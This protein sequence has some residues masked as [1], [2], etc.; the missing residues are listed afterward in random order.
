MK[1]GLRKRSKAAVIVG[2]ALAGAAL[3]GVRADDWGDSFL[4]PRAVDAETWTV[5]VPGKSQRVSRPDSGRESHLR[6]GTMVLGEYAFGRK[7][8]LRPLDP[9]PLEALWVEVER[10]TA[11]IIFPEVEGATR[12]VTL[13]VGVGAARSGNDGAWEPAPEGPLAM[14]V[15]GD[16]LIVQLSAGDRTLGAIGEG[17]I[18]LA[19]AEGGVLSGVR[20]TAGGETILDEDYAALSE[21]APRWLGAALGGAAGLLLGVAL[22]GA[23][24][25]GAAAALLAL[26]PPALVLTTPYWAW[27]RRVETLRLPE[28][29]GWALARWSLA[30]SLIPLVLLAAA[31]WPPMAARG[32]GERGRWAA[33]AIVVGVGLVASRG[34]W[35][36]LLPGLL[37]LGL[38]W[39]LGVRARLPPLPWLA[40]DLPALAAVGLMGWGLGL[41]PATLWRFVPWAASR[42]RLL[43]TPRPAV[44]HLFLLLLLTPLSAELALRASP[45]GEAWRPETLAGEDAAE[46]HLS[47]F[48]MDRCGPEVA[49][50][51]FSL[52]FA[53]GS[54]TGGAYQLLNQ[55]EAFYP[56]RVHETL[57]AQLPEGG[58]LTTWNYGAGGRDTHSFAE[59]MPAL[60]SRTGAD[61][62]VFYVGVNDLLTRDSTLTRRQQ[63]AGAGDSALVGRSRLITGLALSLRGASEPGAL[64]AG[65][66]LADAADNLRRVAEQAA[67]ADGATVL[68]S[69]QHV[70]PSRRAE[71]ASYWAMEAALAD[72]VDNVVF[73]DVRGAFAGADLRET[74]LDDNHF[75]IAGHRCLADALMPA[76]SE[77]LD[78]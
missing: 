36:W 42:R 44:D 16:Q 70:A 74:L 60:L 41:L 65:V 13:E 76:I 15:E 64:V 14:R 47:H 5:I 43:R 25:T 56:A 6:G 17:V 59:D 72:S 45:A 26:V 21:D 53:G 34:A 4:R 11:Q 66:P 24:V 22:A 39:L 7:D 33:A 19:S 9:R 23:G 2:A 54:S 48:W 40:R 51:S 32:E 71:L 67:A 77:A 78:L 29:P 73:V 18:E 50:R 20:A 1:R 27:V 58:A 57:C 62:V 49:E 68:L 69:T 12:R 31:R 10:G 75:T 61:V 46:V 30:A 37:A 35:P 55:P 63:A 52:V 28:T 8:R 38:P 3:G